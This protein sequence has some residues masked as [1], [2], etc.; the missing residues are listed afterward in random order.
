M[1]KSFVLVVAVV[2]MLAMTACGGGS[3]SGSEGSGSENDASTKTLGYFNEYVIGGEYTMEMQLEV[4][5]VTTTTKSAVKGDMLYSETTAGG[6]TSIM[7]MKDDGQYV[8]DP[9]SKTCIKM[10]MEI[11]SMTE[12]FEDEAEAYAVA[13]AAGTVDIGGV[14]YEYEEFV[15]ED[16][17]VKYCFDGSDLKY[18]ITAMDGQEYTM[19]IISMK[20]GADASLFEI[21]SGYTMMEY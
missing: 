4:D 9:A 18:I 13:V 2:L 12:M 10:S 14:T 15:V 1:K 6:M 19:E 11:D 7:I 17:N 21:P 20:K 3:G 8:I 16:T 5:G